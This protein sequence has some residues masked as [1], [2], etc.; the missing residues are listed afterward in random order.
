M[1]GLA[2]IKIWVTDVFTRNF[3]DWEVTGGNNGP[4]IFFDKGKL[5]FPIIGEGNL[6]DKYG[7]NEDHIL[8]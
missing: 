2:T 4:V 3:C 7:L 1:I 8:L 6:L 5:F